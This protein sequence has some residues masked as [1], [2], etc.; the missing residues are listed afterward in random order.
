[1]QTAGKEMAR[2]YDPTRAQTGEGTEFRMEKAV[3]EGNVICEIG[4]M[5][6]PTYLPPEPEEM[7]IFSE[8]RQH[9]GS[10]GNAYP[11]RP[12][13]NATRDTLTDRDY[14]VVRLE[15]KYIRLLILP[16]IKI[17]LTELTR[18]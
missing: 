14:T 10:T 6:I 9:Q 15:N 8:Y 3:T 18:E 11:N 12:T 5:V 13:L 17:I 7:P 4:K 2:K 16:E 1:M